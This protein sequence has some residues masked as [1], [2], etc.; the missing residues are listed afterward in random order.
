MTLEILNILNIYIAAAAGV[1][2]QVSILVRR[3]WSW[4]LFTTA[5]WHANRLVV[6]AIAA[7]ISAKTFVA[8]S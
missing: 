4:A 6:E 3:S 7:G 2:A 8:A 1:V 5:H